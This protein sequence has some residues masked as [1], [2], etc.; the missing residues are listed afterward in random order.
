MINSTSK[1]G[2]DGP[3]ADA[4]YPSWP[5]VA[6]LVSAPSHGDD[7]ECRTLREARIWQSLADEP[8]PQND[9]AC[10]DTY[11]SNSYRR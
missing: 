9:S 3:A 7:T 1:M 4:P 2:S 11:P 10:D 8:M 5:T 6:D